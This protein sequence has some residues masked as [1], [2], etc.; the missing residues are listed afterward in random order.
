MIAPYALVALDIIS[1]MRHH[2][3]VLVLYGKHPMTSS[4][5]IRWGRRGG[6]LLRKLCLCP[7]DLL[8]ILVKLMLVMLS[9]LC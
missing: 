3:C 7:V 1:R 4:R 9:L 2:G 5:T 6:V 8:L